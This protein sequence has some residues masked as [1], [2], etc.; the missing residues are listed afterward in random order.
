MNNII[1]LKYIKTKINLKLNLYHKNRKYEGSLLME[2]SIRC[3]EWS[4]HRI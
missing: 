4:W 1:Q 2:Q 3:K